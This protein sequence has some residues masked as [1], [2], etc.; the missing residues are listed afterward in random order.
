M[1]LG[2]VRSQAWQEEWQ[3]G[4][5][6]GSPADPGAYGLEVEALPGGSARASSMGVRPLAIVSKG[7]EACASSS[8]TPRAARIAA[9]SG[10]LAIVSR[11]CEI[12]VA[13]VYV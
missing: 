6:R 7:L 11:V 3:S 10:W 4:A 8:Y 13:R 12:G 5:R 9:M 2:G 1:V